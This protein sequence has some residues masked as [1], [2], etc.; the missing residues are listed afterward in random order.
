MMNNTQQERYNLKYKWTVS[1]AVDTYGYDICTLF[2]NGDKVSRCNGGGYDMQGTCLGDWIERKF[3]DDLLQL[4]ETFYGLTFHNPNWKPPL[5]I[6][7]KEKE[8]KSLGLERYQDFYKQSSD[9]PTEKHTIPLIDGAC[10]INS[11][12]KILNAIGYKKSCIDYDS[13]I[14]LVEKI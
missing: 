9:L 8:G 5:E 2:V 6:V 3:K 11:V 1:K 4:K 7:E 13:G 12:E 14:Y 10:G